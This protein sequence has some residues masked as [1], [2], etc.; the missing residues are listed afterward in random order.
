L[1]CNSLQSIYIS[2]ATYERLKYRLKDYSSKICF[3]D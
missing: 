2:H 1:S 3:T